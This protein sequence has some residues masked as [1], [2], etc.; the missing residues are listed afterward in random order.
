MNRFL[1]CL[2]FFMLGSA[3]GSFFNVL[4]DRLPEGRDVVFLRSSCSC[5]GTVLKW[6]DLIPVV[7]YIA[8][9][10]KCR[11]CKEKLSP[12]YMISEAAAGLLYALAF[13]CFSK[14]ASAVLLFKLLFLWSILFIVAVMDLKTG[15]IMDLFPLLLA[16]SGFVTGLFEKRPVF[17][18]LAGAFTGAAFFGILYLLARLVLKREGLGV[19]DI[20]LLAGIGFFFPWRQMIILAFM[21]AYIALIFILI[22]MLCRKKIGLKTEFPLGPSI[23]TAAFIMS[24]SGDR[25]TGFISGLLG[26]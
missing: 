3:M 23:C 26:L 13:C 7:S 5:C 25:I 18:I 21:T 11:Y 9:G 19:G 6:Y 17:E 2:W 1:P 10:G 22:L 4:A 15:M 16:V 14:T 20:F 8:L 12:W 24:L